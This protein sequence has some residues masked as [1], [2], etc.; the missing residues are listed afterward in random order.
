MDGMSGLALQQEMS[1]RGIKLPV[2]VITGHGDVGMAV[3][4]M[5]NEAVDFLE[6]PFD[7]AV[8]L[9]LVASTLRAAEDIFAAEEKRRDVAA[10]WEAL[11]K[12]EHQVATLVVQ[13]K[14]NREIAEQLSISIKTV[15]IHRSRVM[16]KMQ[17][18]K[19]AELVS[20]AGDFV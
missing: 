5:K 20:L 3:Q 9:E 18:K 2:I 1:K 15:E 6:K 12:R 13:G 16:Q 4:A 14:A 7:D 8:L 11:S 17:T 10:R 19:V